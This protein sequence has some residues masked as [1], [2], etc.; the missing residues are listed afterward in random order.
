MNILLDYLLPFI[1]ALG[2]LIFFHELGHYAVARWN[3]VKV[4]R[5]SVGFGKPLLRWHVGRDRTEWVLAAIPLGGYVKMLD[6]REAP[7]A[8][9]ELSRSLTASPLGDASPSLRRGRWR[10][11][12]LQSCFTG[13]YSSAEWRNCSRVWRNR[14]L[15]R[16]RRWQ[17]SATEIWC[18][19]S[20]PRRCAAGEN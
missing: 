20:M 3:G 16:R 11:F 13:A 15:P 10:I 2:A 1:V 9:E 6:E 4:L 7:V 14:N 5:F 19:R 17:A 18:Y 12:Y 8:Q